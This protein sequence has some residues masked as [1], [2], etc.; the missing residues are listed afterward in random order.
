MSV[1]LVAVILRTNSLSPGFPGTIAA[2]PSRAATALSRTSSRSFAPAY[3]LTGRECLRYSACGQCKL[4]RTMPLHGTL[5]P[6]VVRPATFVRSLD[7][8]YE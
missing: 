8:A 1:G 5:H 3:A 2:I 6:A 4:S 7:H